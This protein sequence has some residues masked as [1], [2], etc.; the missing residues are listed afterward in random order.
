ML[1]RSMRSL[2]VLALAPVV[3]ATVLVAL[4]SPPASAGTSVGRTVI[5]G[6]VVEPSKNRIKISY[7]NDIDLPGLAQVHVRVYPHATTRA[8]LSSG[9][10]SVKKGK[11]VKYLTTKSL[12]QVLRIRMTV[13]R[14]A[15]V[16]FIRVAKPSSTTVARVVSKSDAV[17]NAVAPH[18]AGA[19]L[20]I[21]PQTRAVKVA[22][23]L[24]LGWTVGSDVKKSLRGSGG[25][26]PKL[27]AGQYIRTTSSYAQSGKK[28]KQTIRYKVWH[29]KKRYTNGKAPACNVVTTHTFG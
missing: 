24:I 21:V 2:M 17:A 25:T 26:C 28:V 3:L 13:D 29:S 11:H 27:A 10:L 20:T 12:I 9:H 22:G 5:T 23:A 16:D 6:V 7:K 19:I 15:P 8:Q 1:S 4:A 14:L 18:V